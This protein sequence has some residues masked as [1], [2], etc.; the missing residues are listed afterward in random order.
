MSAESKKQASDFFEHF[1][2]PED[3]LEN[4]VKR[5]FDGYKLTDEE[6]KMLFSK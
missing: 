5:A 4:A 3:F 6:R 1:P 2:T